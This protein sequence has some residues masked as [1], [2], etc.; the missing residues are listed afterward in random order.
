[1][2]RGRRA[3]R[4]LHRRRAGRDCRNSMRIAPQNRGDPLPTAATS[5]QAR[6]HSTTT[7][8]APCGGPGTA[9]AC[10]ENRV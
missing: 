6:H 2:T 8:D 1:M 10:G 3:V 7:D 9:A 4:R 5:L